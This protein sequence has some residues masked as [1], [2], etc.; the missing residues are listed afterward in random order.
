VMEADQRDGVL[1]LLV[2][3]DGIGGAAKAAGHGISG[4]LDRVAAHGGMLAI[5]SPPGGGTRVAVQLPCGS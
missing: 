2:A 1:H 3:D 4:M 5:E